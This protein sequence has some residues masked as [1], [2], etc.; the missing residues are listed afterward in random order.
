MAPRLRTDRV[1]GMPANLTPAYRTAEGHYRHAREPADKLAAL[2]EM[3]RA[4]PKHK[5]TEHLQSDIKAKIKEMSD[6]L[7]GPS[8]GGAR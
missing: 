3:L 1:V 8:K 7:A 5:G 4:I 2:K 6:E